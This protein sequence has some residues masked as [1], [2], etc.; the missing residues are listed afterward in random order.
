MIGGPEDGP[1]VGGSPQKSGRRA[2]CEPDGHRTRLRRKRKRPKHRFLQ[3]SGSCAAQSGHM[4]GKPRE[5]RSL[6]ASPSPTTDGPGKDGACAQEGRE[7][8]AQRCSIP[9]ATRTSGPKR[10]PCGD[11]VEKWLGS[12]PKAQRQAPSPSAGPWLPVRQSCSSLRG[13]GGL[14]QAAEP[15]DGV[16]GPTDSGDRA[17]GA[18]K[19]RRGEKRRGKG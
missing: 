11:G 16:A 3:E 7:Q 8:H 10:K 19:G 6:K 14:P 15:E 1:G 2:N 17:R 9:A 12:Q 4:F 18:K 13:L 5:A